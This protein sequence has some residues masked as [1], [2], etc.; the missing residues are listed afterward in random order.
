LILAVCSKDVVDNLKDYREKFSG[1]YTCH[2]TGAYSCLLDTNIIRYDSN[3]IVNVSKCDDSSIIILDIAI[4][5]EAD[6][7]FSS[8]VP[9]LNYHG[10]GGYFINDSLIFN[11]FQGGL[12]CNTILNY[13]RKNNK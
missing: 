2:M 1:N 8:S 13:N 4:K 12:G 7:N 10:I 6:G 5:I 9:V 3:I 11:T